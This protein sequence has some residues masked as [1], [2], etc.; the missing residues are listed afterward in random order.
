ME[1]RQGLLRT[2]LNQHRR[3]I[4]RQPLNEIDVADRRHQVG[5]QVPTNLAR[6]RDVGIVD[7]AQQRN[8]R[9]V[10][11]SRIECRDQRSG[12]LL[13]QRRMERRRNG[14]R[15]RLIS[16][17]FD[18][19]CEPSQGFGAPSRNR[20]VGRVVIG[21]KNLPCELRLAGD[22]LDQICW[23]AGRQHRAPS[24]RTGIDPIAS[25]AG[26]R[27][28]LLKTPGPCRQQSREFAVAM[29]RNH[30]SLNSHFSQGSMNDGI[31]DQDGQLRRPHIVPEIRVLFPSHFRKRRVSLPS[32]CGVH[33]SH[34]SRGC[35]RG[36]H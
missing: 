5:H 4:L 16:L 17:L 27:E 3:F 7:D 13:H 33:S 12:S 29:T 8:P 6:V 34:R 1:S 11:L 30:V 23:R 10:D 24:G 18:R 2:D 35:R 22:R 25:R 19:H 21:K 9:R 31:G 14:D 26:H 15:F 28:H 36:C 20:L 32:E